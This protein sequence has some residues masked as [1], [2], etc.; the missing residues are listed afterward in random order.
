MQIGGPFLPWFDR[1]MVKR[2]RVARIKLWFPGS[3][4][5]LRHHLGGLMVLLEFE[6]IRK[7]LVCTRV[8]MSPRRDRPRETHG[9]KMARRKVCQLS[10]LAQADQGVARGGN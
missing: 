10:T 5:K 6:S 3:V 7:K 4:I 1:W 8:S 9:R 2:E